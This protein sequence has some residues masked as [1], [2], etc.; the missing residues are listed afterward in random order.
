MTKRLFF[1]VILVVFIGA[2]L[3]FK[4]WADSKQDTIQNLYKAAK[5]EGQVW[6]QV[7]GPP[8]SWKPM[9]E[10]FQTK[11]PGIKV[12]VFSARGSGMAARVITESTAGKIS[13]DVI[14][15]NPETMQPLIERDLLAHYDWT[16]ISDVNPDFIMLE[17]RFVHQWDDPVIWVYNTQFVSESDVPRSWEDLLDPRWKDFKISMRSG[18]AHVVGL[19]PAWLENPQKVINY[20][21][22]LREQ[23]I[24][25]ASRTSEGANR[26]VTGQNLIGIMRAS[27]YLI[28]KKKGTPIGVCPISPV[29]NTP[30]GF[31]LPKAK[32]VPHPNAGRLLIGWA[33]SREGRNVFTENNRGL[34]TPCDASSLARLLCDNGIKFR[35]IEAMEEL[36]RYMIFEH[37]AA[38][39]LGFVSE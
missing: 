28:L 9:A 13:M 19:F 1:L 11:Y 22:K 32:G 10:A 34:G 26:I 17:S 16:K 5:T 23:K 38:V 31:L 3:P 36:K 35:R 18:G 6:W 24:M 21:E 2:T 25:S 4:S 12:K 14:T 15:S 20:L 8:G 29:L 37:D 39:A 27:D 30:H 33:V 7:L